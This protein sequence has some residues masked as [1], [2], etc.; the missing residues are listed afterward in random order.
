MEIKR[1]IFGI[2]LIGPDI[3][4]SRAGFTLCMDWGILSTNG[5]N[6]IACHNILWL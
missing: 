2:V 6:R 4:D 5:I 3:M 1:L